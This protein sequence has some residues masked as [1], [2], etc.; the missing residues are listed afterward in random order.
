M[1]ESSMRGLSA[2]CWAL[3]D[4]ILEANHVAAP[5]WKHFD[6]TQVASYF[7]R[8]ILLTENPMFTTG[9]IKD[10]EYRQKV[11]PEELDGLLATG[12]LLNV[13]LTLLV[14]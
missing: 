5:C 12:W 11:S 3:R 2:N 9:L 1:N 8:P 14:S 7:G 6:Q 4:L 10:H 13:R